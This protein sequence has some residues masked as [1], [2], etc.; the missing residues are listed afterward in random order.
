MASNINKSKKLLLRNI[1]P[2]VTESKLRVIISEIHNVEESN[3]VDIIFNADTNLALVTFDSEIVAQD[4]FEILNSFPLGPD[5][6]PIEVT[7]VT[8]TPDVQALPSVTYAYEESVVDKHDKEDLYLERGRKRVTSSVMKESVMKD[9][10]FQSG[11]RRDGENVPKMTTSEKGIEIGRPLKFF[12]PPP[13]EEESLKTKSGEGK[14]RKQNPVDEDI[15]DVENDQRQRQ[16]KTKKA[17]ASQS[18]AKSKKT[19]SHVLKIKK[20]DNA[21]D[22]ETFTIYLNTRGVIFAKMDF[23]SEDDGEDT[24]EAT[25]FF[26]SEGEALAARD[27]LKAKCAIGIEGAEAEVTLEAVDQPYLKNSVKE[28]ANQNVDEE[29][30]KS[31]SEKKKPSRQ[32]KKKTVNKD[33]TPKSGSQQSSTPIE[34][35]NVPSNQEYIQQ[36]PLSPMPNLP[37]NQP[38]YVQPSTMTYPNM[39]PNTLQANTNMQHPPGGY[40]NPGLPQN[41]NP[42]MCLPNQNQPMYNPN[43]GRNTSQANTNMQHPP[44]GYFNPGPPQNTHPGM[45]LPNQNQPMY[46]PNMGPEG[47]HG[48]NNMTSTQFSGPPPLMNLPEAPA[49]PDGFHH[50]SGPQANPSSRG[51]LLTNPRMTAPMNQPSQ[52]FN[53]S[54]MRQPPNKDLNPTGVPRSQ[55]CVTPQQN[56]NGPTYLNQ[57]QPN[58]YP[59]SHMQSSRQQVRNS[60][61]SSIPTKPR[62]AP[63]SSSKALDKPDTGAQEVRNADALNDVRP[64]LAPKPGKKDTKAKPTKHS[65]EHEHDKDGI[66]SER[67][68]KTTQHEGKPRGRS[69]PSDAGHSGDRGKTPGRKAKQS[70][71]KLSMLETETTEEKMSRMFNSAPDDNLQ[72]FQEEVTGVDNDDNDSVYSNISSASTNRRQAR[73]R[74]TMATSLIV[75]GFDSSANKASFEAFLRAQSIK[76]TSCSLR[77]GSRDKE[78]SAVVRFCTP[79]ETTT[80]KTGIHG[81][82]M[83]SPDGKGNM[84]KAVY[85][86][87]TG[88]AGRKGPMR[89]SR[90]SADNKSDVGSSLS[91]RSRP[92]QQLS[93]SLEITG[94][95][96]HAID[97]ALLSNCLQEQKD[98][99][100][101]K[102]YEFKTDEK[103]NMFALLHFHVPK[104]CSHA[105]SILHGKPLATGGNQVKASYPRVHGKPSE[106]TSRQPKHSEGDGVPGKRRG[107]SA[108]FRQPDQHG[109]TT[110]TAGP[111][112]NRGTDGV[113]IHQY[114]VKVTT[115]DESVDE[116]AFCKSLRRKRIR[117]NNIQWLRVNK[118]VVSNQANLYFSTMEEAKAAADKLNGSLFG[119]GEIPVKAEVITTKSAEKF[120]RRTRRKGPKTNT[121]ANDKDQNNVEDDDDD[122]DSLD[123]DSDI[124]SVVSAKG[125]KTNKRKRHEIRRKQRLTTSITVTNIDP[126]ADEDDFRDFLLNQLED[127]AELQFIPNIATKKS[128]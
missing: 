97:P 89:A 52:Q 70:R 75:T 41:M 3:I 116:D 65:N 30:S 108:S 15:L 88:V 96:S 98:R 111:G 86:H 29:D 34:Q 19:G 5:F 84:L 115:I 62:K 92:N 22:L 33:D 59:G 42:G 109:K 54:Y 101:I 4:A 82:I 47:S 119:E 107:S 63:S 38:R 122:A 14:S 78:P 112:S 10:E 23:I 58:M 12:E 85:L 87:K 100:K 17:S 49:Q 21:V 16:S 76:Y 68:N 43:M 39:G 48:H 71:D 25:L 90:P 125:S 99:L 64:K 79:R 13:R 83:Q 27:S 104:D 113:R 95:S 118:P 11:R 127:F 51:P 44:G 6:T 28:K 57:Q 91:S 93:T 80:G 114:Y 1:C 128:R 56:Y 94:M 77:T 61:K 81:A 35:P 120:K 8:N 31:K 32:R 9:H 69:K 7:F 117:P 74:Q 105:R 45:R 121:G 110:H 126:S 73:S 18:K 46:N 20:I 106:T 72:K 53:P 37:F 124:S 102:S 67:K 36:V 2:N 66:S 24:N 60:T 26:S 103:Q 40:F 50:P 123:V 55:R